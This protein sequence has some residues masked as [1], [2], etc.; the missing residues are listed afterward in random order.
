MAT[1]DKS[2]YW[3]RMCLNGRVE[4][5]WSN[6]DT[7]AHFFAEAKRATEIVQGLRDLHGGGPSEPVWRDPQFGKARP[8]KPHPEQVSMET[9][10][11]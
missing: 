5:H 4:C 1:K 2:S 8:A 9:G 11:A 10:N 6:G 3:M 7:H